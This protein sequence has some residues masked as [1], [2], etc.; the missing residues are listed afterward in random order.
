MR[1]LNPKK[2]IEK[3]RTQSDKDTD[4]EIAEL[5]KSAKENADLLEKMDVSTE[6][7][8]EIPKLKANVEPEKQTQGLYAVEMIIGGLMARLKEKKEDIDLTQ[9]SASTLATKATSSGVKVHGFETA[10]IEK[11]NELTGQGGPTGK[12]LQEAWQEITSNAQEKSKKWLDELGDMWKRDK[13]ATIG[14]L[15]VGAVGAY[16]GYKVL[17]GIFDWGRKDETP[18]TLGQG[19]EKGFFESLM[20]SKKTMGILGILLLGLFLGRGELKKLLYAKMGIKIGDADL[21]DIA[22]KMKDGKLKEAEERIAALE[23]AAAAKAAEGED[24][25]KGLLDK[26][27]EQA[28]ILKKEADFDGP[29]SLLIALHCLNERRYQPGDKAEILNI[30][31]RLKEKKVGDIAAFWQKFKDMGEEGTI[32]ND[33]ELMP[34]NNVKPENIY[35]AF[36]IIAS[37]YYGLQ[38]GM[39]GR[40]DYGSMLLKDFVEK[41]LAEDPAHKINKNVQESLKKAIAAGSYE[42]V[43]LKQSIKKAVHGA[44]K[45]DE[46]GKFLEDLSR[47]LGIET[48]LLTKEEKRDFRAIAFKDIFRGATLNMKTK[49]VLSNARAEGRSINAILAAEK[50]FE[51]IKKRTLEDIIPNCI[52]R[53][54]LPTESIGNPKNNS[55]L[56]QR[57][58]DSPEP[59]AFSDAVYLNF[60]SKNIDFKNPEQKVGQPT[61]LALLYTLLN[62]V[63]PEVK[64]RYLSE[65]VYVLS[66]AETNFNIKLPDLA[67]LKPY[68]SRLQEYAK[69]RIENV[70]KTAEEALS[71]WTDELPPERRKQFLGQMAKADFLTFGGGFGQEAVR[72]SIVMAKDSIAPFRAALDVSDEEWKEALDGGWTAMLSLIVSQGFTLFFSREEPH[73]GYIQVGLKHIFFKPMGAAVDAVKAWINGDVGE[74]LKVWAVGTSPYIAIGTTVGILKAKGGPLSKVWGGVKGFRKGFTTPITLPTKSAYKL[75]RFGKEKGLAAVSILKYRKSPSQAINLMLRDAKMLRHY[76][77]V[78]PL[79]KMGLWKRAKYAWAAG[80]KKEFSRLLMPDWNKR[81]LHIYTQRF[82]DRYDGIFGGRGRGEITVLKEGSEA[83]DI[84]KAYNKAEKLDDFFSKLI[85]HPEFKNADSYKKLKPIIKEIGVIN[86][87]EREY[88]LGQLKNPKYVKKFIGMVTDGSQYLSNKEIIEAVAGTKKFN[89]LLKTLAKQVDADKIQK[90]LAKKGVTIDRKTAELIA[91]TK[92]QNKIKEILSKMESGAPAAVTQVEA[93]TFYARE[94]EEIG[95]L[96]SKLS[97]EMRLDVRAKLQGQIDDIKKGIQNSLKERGLAAESEVIE[98]MLKGGSA[99]DIKHVL[100]EG[101]KIGTSGKTESRLAK[102]RKAIGEKAGKAKEK[103]SNVY[104]NVAKRFDRYA[105][106]EGN[107]QKMLANAE[108]DMT[109]IEKAIARANKMKNAAKAEELLNKAAEAKK[110]MEKL[111]AQLNELKKVEEAMKTAKGSAETL[112]TTQKAVEAAMENSQKAFKAINESSKLIKALKF[113]KGGGKALFV[114]APAVGAWSS[115]SHLYEAVSTDNPERVGMETAMGGLYLANTAIDTAFAMTLFGKGG[116]ATKALGRAWVPATFV[117]YAGEKMYEV[118]EERVRSEAEWL[119]S[120]PYDDLIHQWF[121]TYHGVNLGE[122]WI[123]GFKASG[124]AFGE[125]N[126]YAYQKALD[127]EVDKGIEEKKKIMH[128]MF[129]ALI[130]AHKNPEI[131]NIMFDENKKQGAKNYE[132]NEAIEKSYTKYHEYYFQHSIATS[133]KNYGAA[134]QF[135]ADAQLFD[136]LMQMRE[137]KKRAG[138]ELKFVSEGTVYD[139]MDERYDIT[140][141]SFSPEAKRDFAPYLLIDAYKSHLLTFDKKENPYLEENLEKMDTFYLLRLYVQIHKVT[142]DPEAEKKLAENPGIMYAMREYATMIRNYLVAKRSVHWKMALS[143]PKLFEPPM[144]LDEVLTNLNDMDVKNSPSYQQFEKNIPEESRKPG[145]YAM[146]RLAEYFGYTGDADE[147]TIKEFFCEEKEEFHG[148]YWDGSEWHMFNPGLSFD[149][150]LDEQDMNK[151]GFIKEVVERFYQN[152]NDVLGYRHRSFVVS[153]TE[154]I[155]DAQCFNFAYQVRSM[156]EILQNGYN[157]AIRKFHKGRKE[158]GH[159][160]PASF[161]N[162][163]PKESEHFEQEYTAEIT[164]IKEGMNWSQLDFEVKDQNTI[165]LKRL[166]S[167]AKTTIK[168]SGDTWNIEN[169][170]TSLNF[171]QAVSMSNLLNWIKGESAKHHWVAGAERPFEVDGGDID[172]D[173]AGIIDTEVLDADRS[174]NW[175]K[176]YEKIG[177]PKEKMVEILNNWWEKEKAKAT[178]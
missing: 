127:K 151:E 76:Y 159:I 30:C 51:T 149:L 78:K 36:N 150:T 10:A 16:L 3:L 12:H 158:I 50:F 141:T 165:L 32:P 167:D 56:L 75:Y 82:A 66:N 83:I 9:L 129:K 147:A 73:M 61:Q 58:F 117:V 137:E 40:F 63:S 15:A 39:G 7:V 164:R 21:D 162:Q 84:D 111:V 67:I 100:E 154:F 148:I 38:K 139:L 176:F 43:E 107:L 161:E 124:S 70:A 98:Q 71:P 143:N 33:N 91:D 80:T 85:S 123:S 86:G 25:A 132:I 44:E 23:A 93:A 59:I 110:E 125:T 69:Q 52:K 6:D 27:K 74:G 64:T 96:E 68:F 60:V 57:Y 22:G 140:G 171:A 128:K 87:S 37:T 53:F 133:V 177:L 178:V 121:T 24:K 5:K 130:A 34:I 138:G 31:K 173:K 92:D 28:D 20:P 168:K 77:S 101:E 114:A 122:S 118:A 102:L 1:D 108:A 144:T 89:Q 175:I 97:T 19:S 109:T 8:M 35:A 48:Q 94:L 55:N 145:L 160:A 2:A 18:E 81:M 62:T 134:K 42:I 65:L 113:L 131:Y 157:E 90:T 103:L 45:K 116:A 174:G 169:Y 46:K 29:V 95:I 172:F 152:S 54:E 105:Q 106:A 14:L 153:T 49:D 119:Q 4:R 41:H 104:K 115:G 17:K 72:G 13:T 79:A 155:H 136:D 163:E 47:H 166:D 126:P 26:G 170:A 135:I 156:A 88:L 99:E 112:K 11:Y 146:Y 120:Y 142:E